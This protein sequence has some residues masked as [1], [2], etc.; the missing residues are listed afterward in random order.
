MVTLGLWTIGVPGLAAG[1]A[2]DRHS[3]ISASASALALAIALGG[4]NL[5]LGIR[6]L[7]SREVGPSL[8]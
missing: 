5:G 1:L 7:W 2:L 8:P 6:R 4:A 3:W